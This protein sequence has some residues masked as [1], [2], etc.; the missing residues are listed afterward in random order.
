M[1]IIYFNGDVKIFYRKTL[2]GRIIHFLR[3]QFDHFLDYI[4]GK[5]IKYPEA[6]YC[7]TCQTTTK[8]SIERF[9]MECEGTKGR[10]RYA[11]RSCGDRKAVRGFIWCAPCAI[12]NGDNWEN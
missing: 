2:C 4:E 3:E 6:T 1:K 10:K 5:F 7:P 11:C 8:D 12:E 9:C